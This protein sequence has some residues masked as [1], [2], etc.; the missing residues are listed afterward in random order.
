M[1]T[2]PLGDRPELTTK[3]LTLNMLNDL[4]NG[5]FQEIF[6]LAMNNYVAQKGIIEIQKVPS[7]DLGSTKGIPTR[8]ATLGA[9]V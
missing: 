5:M 4:M 2:L 9:T 7:E 1:T 8:L 6:N 3:A